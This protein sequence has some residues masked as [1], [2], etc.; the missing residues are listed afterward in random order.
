MA[1]V[2]PKTNKEHDL[3]TAA[4][5]WGTVYAGTMNVDGNLTV[6]GAITTTVS[7]TLEVEDAT[8]KLAKGNTTSDDVDFGVYGVYDEGGTDKYS[9]IF[10][11][12]DDS[13]KWKIWTGFTNEPPSLGDVNLGSGTVGTLV[14]KLQTDAITGWSSTDAANEDLSITP[15]GTGNLNV[16]ADTLRVGDSNADAVITTNGTGDLT[17]STNSG[18]NSGTVVIADGA[19]GNITI[20]PNG[21]GQVNVATG[22]AVA[23]TAVT[24]TAAELNYLD[25]ANLTADDLT[26]LAAVTATA[27]EL[28]YLRVDDLEAADLTK[29]AAVTATAAKLN[30]TDVTTLGTSE[31]SKVVTQSTTGTIIVGATNGNQTIDIASHDLVDGGLKLG[32]TLVKASAAELNLL[33]TAVA[34]TIVDSKA[35]IYGSAGEIASNKLSV[36]QDG[37]GVNNAGSITLGADNDAGLWVASNTHL[38]VQNDTVNADIIFRTNNGTVAQEIM[39]VDGGASKVTIKELSVTG[40]ITGGAASTI[41]FSGGVEHSV[42]AITADTTLNDTH[43]LVKTSANLTLP[44]AEVNEGREYIITCTTDSKTLTVGETGDMLY[45]S[46]DKTAASDGTDLTD[47]NDVFAMRNKTVYRVISD[48]VNWYVV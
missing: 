26:K 36:D 18:T 3:G 25:N 31:N 5:R 17:L 28:N 9:I 19:D 30:Y 39:R 16:V 22:L 15:L 10:R 8:I 6:S 41:K 13:G 4:L 11:D 12:N 40:V 46:A 34:D 47:T 44:G 48:G 43:Y 33:D 37:D 1:A 27:A 38:Y 21:S 14:T 29:L 45:Y 7:Q 24:A 2:A 23:G 20:T 32:G 35:V 42:D